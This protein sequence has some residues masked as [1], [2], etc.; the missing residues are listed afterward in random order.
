MTGYKNFLTRK[1][2]QIKMSSV[3]PFSF[4]AVELCVVT[5]NENPWTR[6]KE[7]CRALE[8]NKKTAD[9]VKAFCYRENYTQKYQ[10]S[11]FTV[12]G[13]PVD[14]PKDSQKYDI[15]LNEE[16]MYEIVFSIQQPKAK[17]FGKHCF[18]VL[19]PHVCQQLSDKSRAM[20]IE[21]L[22]DCIQSLAFTNE[23]HQQSIEEKDVRIALLNDDLHN[24]KHE[25]VGLQGEIRAKDQQIAA[26]QR[27]YVG[28]LS[29]EDKNS[30]ISIIAKNNEK[31][32]PYIS[33]CG[34]HGY[35][36]HN[37][38]VLLAR[39]KGS[40]LFVDGDTPN[41]IVTYNF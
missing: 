16:G 15:Y 40:T 17:A 37:T 18:N 8:Y 10:M 23:T 5:I 30:D 27:R 20:E 32:Y 25:N 28:Y 22:A 11:G 26:L 34:Q 9:I 4:N 41:A 6:A 36:R 14:W 3:M 31:K 7:V 1:E 13:K 19:F 2:L 24:R 29:D 38:R 33:I 12:A 39:N 21:D 35:R